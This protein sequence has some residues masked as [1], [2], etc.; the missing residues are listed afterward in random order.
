MPARA[1][2]I[3]QEVKALGWTDTKF[4][5]EPI[6]FGCLPSELPALREV[7]PHVHYFSPNH[8]EA[9]WFWKLQVEEETD[10]PARIED[11]AQRFLDEGVPNNVIIRSGK[12]GAYVLQRGQAGKWV[13]PYHTSGEKVVD[14]TGC[15]NAFIGGMIAGLSITRG[16]L[17]KA[18]VYGSVSASYTLEQYGLPLMGKDGVWNGRDKPVER[19]DQLSTRLGLDMQ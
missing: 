9:G 16:D 14:V 2:E 7:L 1:L 15:G 10:K 12:L 8:E 4:V 6:P 18:C 17:V 11:L 5:Y 3:I 19:L 13:A